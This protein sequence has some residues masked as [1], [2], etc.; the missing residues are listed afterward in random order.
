MTYIYL[1]KEHW[2]FY[3]NEADEYVGAF[4]TEEEATKW[5]DERVEIHK[6][7]YGIEKK[8]LGKSFR[9]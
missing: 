1:V 5:V 3:I 4:S 2:G 7:K 8:V 9:D 6:L